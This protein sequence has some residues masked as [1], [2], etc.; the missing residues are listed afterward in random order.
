M[1]TIDSTDPDAISELH[2]VF[3]PRLIAKGNPSMRVV[4]L[5]IE[6]D[7]AETLAFD[8][9]P[10]LPFNEQW[11]HAVNTMSEAFLSEDS[12]IRKAAEANFNTQ[13]GTLVQP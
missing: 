3:Q 4:L 1:T 2:L 7:N 12:P 11:E 5:H 6:K 9:Q 10:G 8:T 13:F